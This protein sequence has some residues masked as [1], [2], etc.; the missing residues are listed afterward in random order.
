MEKLLLE[1]EAH[2]TYLYEFEHAQQLRALMANAADHCDVHICGTGDHANEKEIKKGSFTDI[3]SEALGINITEDTSSVA[4][5]APEVSMEKRAGAVIVSFN[6]KTYSAPREL[7]LLGLNKT[8]APVK[9]S[10]RPKA[11][12]YELAKADVDNLLGV[13]GKIIKQNTVYKATKN[14]GT[15]VFSYMTPQDFCELS[16]ISI[17]RN[18]NAV[19][20]HKTIKLIQL[21]NGFGIKLGPDTICV[22]TEASPFFNANAKCYI[23]QQDLDTHRTYLEPVRIS[24]SK[25]FNTALK[26]YTYDIS[27]EN[28][29]KLYDVPESELVHETVEAPIE[30]TKTVNTSHF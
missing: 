1:K 12:R 2:P 10:Y 17:L 18:G 16:G 26:Q 20:G 23:R 28:G 22:L 21:T 24:V 14:N 27:M 11:T 8:A 19:C 7:G 4:M 6:D 29:N 13:L 9:L 25:G 3:V 5:L 15:P 30:G